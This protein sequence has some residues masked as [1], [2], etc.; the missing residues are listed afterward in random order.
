[1]LAGATHRHRAAVALLAAAVGIP[2]LVWAVVQTASD[3]TTAYYSTLTRGW[4]LALGA[5]LAC[6]PAGAGG[7]P[8]Y[9]VRL[10][11]AAR[12]AL[13]WAGL[14]ILLGACLLL[15]PDTGVPYPAALGATVGTALVLLAGIG[16][17]A[18]GSAARSC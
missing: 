8:G 1:M 18:D 12:A 13:S 16:A 7:Q 15:S 3:P 5:A 9:A 6:I 10:A 4:E 17:P 11:P 14:A 2:S